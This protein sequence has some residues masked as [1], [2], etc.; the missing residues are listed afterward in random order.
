MVAELVHSRQ[1]DIVIL[2][3]C[4][5]G[6]GE[7]LK[8][9]NA[10]TGD[11]FHHSESPVKMKTI[12]VFTRFSKQFIRPVDESRRYSLRHLALPGRKDLLL[13]LV[14]FPSK[15][16]WTEDSQVQECVELAKMIDSAEKRIGH[17]RTVLVGDL[18][19]NP[20]EKGVVGATGLNAT[21]SHSRALKELRT[22]QNREYRFFYNPMWRHFGDGQKEPPGTY[23]YDNSQHV[24]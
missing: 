5:A 18:N 21:M 24:T 17:F 23:H 12:Q 22:V 15:L 19:M 20:F 10:A 6:V 11:I 3:E 16:R 14:H 1:V 2:V 4:T 8:A 7:I 9:L 13:A